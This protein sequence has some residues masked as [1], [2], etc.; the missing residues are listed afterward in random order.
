MFIIMRYDMNRRQTS[1]QKEAE[2]QA[3]TKLLNVLKQQHQSVPSNDL[4]LASSSLISPSSLL[5]GSTTVNSQRI[6]TS[7]ESD[8]TEID[9]LKKLA[10]MDMALQEK[11]SS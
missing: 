6:D 4:L 11:I 10:L 9:P 2:R 8:Q 5:K 3:A 1:E 7:P